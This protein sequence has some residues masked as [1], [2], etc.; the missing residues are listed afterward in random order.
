MTRVAGF[1]D[2]PDL[3]SIFFKK[4]YLLILSYWALSYLFYLSFLFLGLSE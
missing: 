4:I 1:E 3:T 2:Y